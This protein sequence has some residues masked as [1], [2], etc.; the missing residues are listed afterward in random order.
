MIR[1]LSPRLKPLSEG[2]VKALRLVQDMTNALDSRIQMV[3]D[4][5]A[6]G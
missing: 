2:F 3:D 1:M 4:L 5:R 6:R